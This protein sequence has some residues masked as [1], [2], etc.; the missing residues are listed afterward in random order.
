MSWDELFYSLLISV[1]VL[2]YQRVVSRLFKLHHRRQ[3][4][5]SLDR[6]SAPYT[7]HSVGDYFSSYNQSQCRLFIYEVIR[8]VNVRRS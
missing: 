5:G 7:H 4:C 3:F 1:R 6:A 2:Y 8:H